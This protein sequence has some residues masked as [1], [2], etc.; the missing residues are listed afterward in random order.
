M[1]PGMRAFLLAVSASLAFAGLALANG[2]DLVPAGACGRNEIANFGDSLPV[3]ASG[4][5][6]DGC[7]G[8]DPVNGESIFIWA[9]DDPAESGQ[10]LMDSLSTDITGGAPGLNE[11]QLA[12]RRAI[13]YSIGAGVGT[14]YVFN[15]GEVVYVIQGTTRAAAERA[16]QRIG[17]GG[18]GGGSGPGLTESVPGPADI[19]VDPIVIATSVAAAAGVAVAAP[20]PSTLFNSTLEAN[21]EEVSGWFRRLRRRVSGAGSALGARLSAFFATPRGLAA[22]IGIAALMYGFINPWFGFNLESAATV[23]G[24]W[25][26]IAALAAADQLPARAFTRRRTGE[27]GE[28]RVHMAGLLIGLGC[29]VITRI[30]DFQPGYLYG[31]VVAY[32]FTRG[33]EPKDNGRASALGSA[34]SLALSVAAFV[35]LG[36]VRAPFGADVPLFVLPVTA[37]LAVMVV[38]GIEDV[39]FGLLPLR[40]LPGQAIMAWSKPIWALLFGASAF[41][42]LHVL[43]NPASGYLADTTLQPLSKVIALFVGFG[44]VSVLFWAFFRYRRPR[45][46]ATVSPSSATPT[47]NDSEAEGSER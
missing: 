38:G 43:V 23:V 8:S 19:S 9:F 29:V 15:I 1:R 12:G 5:R 27:A 33:L 47:K 34:A 10:Q 44:L 42:F 30:T 25:V 20:F 26:G 41:A 45:A 39:L 24:V 2:S 17:A 40:Y 18:G 28:L 22:F 7:F 31:I 4:M 35:A 14:Y 37:A 46:A 13:E 11:V 3:D 21:Y 6:F 32:V 36:A 16:V